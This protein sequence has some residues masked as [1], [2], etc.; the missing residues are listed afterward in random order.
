MLA[1]TPLK[2]KNLNI[3]MLAN[4]V[5]EL[6]QLQVLEEGDS[7]SQSNLPEAIKNSLEQY[8]EIFQEPQSLPPVRPIDHRIPLDLVTKPVCVRPYRYPQ[9]QKIEIERLVGEMHST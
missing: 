4:T 5:S 3:F 9:F 6:Y 7:Q 2:G 1:S 8:S